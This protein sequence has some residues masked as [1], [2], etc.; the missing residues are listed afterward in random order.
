MLLIA[1]GVETEEQLMLLH[2][3]AVPKVQGYFL[4]RPAPAEQVAAAAARA[5]RKLTRVLRRHGLEPGASGARGNELAEPDHK[6][7][8]L[9]E[10]AMVE[11]LVA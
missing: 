1:E 3:L 5:E 4:G 6:A 9:R 8:W 11:P 7:S 2:R 10:A